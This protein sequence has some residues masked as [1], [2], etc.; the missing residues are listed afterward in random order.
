MRLTFL[1][2]LALRAVILVAVIVIFGA[3]AIAALNL[4]LTSYIDGPDFRAELDRQT[5]KGL[6]FD[7]KYGTIKRSGFLTA[8]ADTFHAENGVKAMK[9][10]DASGIDAKFNPLGVFLRRWQL[11]YVRIK[12]GDVEI[13]TYEPKPDRKPQKPWYS[14]IMPERVHLKEVI[15][16]TANIRWNIRNKPGGILDTY[17]RILPYGRDF[18]YFADGGRFETGGLTPSLEVRKIHLTITKKALTVY[19]FELFPQGSTDSLLSMTG[20]VGMREDKHVDLRLDIK[21]MPIAPWLP[22]EVEGETGGNVTGF[23]EWKADGQTIEA[24]SGSGGLSVSGGRLSGLPLLE[25]L[26]SAA[27]EKN[28][29]TLTL[30]ECN[31]EFQWKY[32]RFEISSISLEAEEKVALRGSLAVRNG[33]LDGTCE[34]GLDPEY[35]DWLPKAEEEVFTRRE[36]GMIW[37]TV[38]ISGTLAKPEN[39]LTPRLKEA[40]KKDPAAAA[41]LFLRGAGEWIEQKLKG[42]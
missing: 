19:Q 41:G 30:R 23:V 6:H 5:S 31:V 12:H 39:D 37:T 17:V 9:R 32:P 2:R 33:K 24:S 26:A 20:D 15:C 36:N 40:L 28:L 21:N 7:G 18:R 3:L 25:F 34:L 29:K 8:E 22:S 11:D 1:P 16:D 4:R 14:F 35:L 42:N 38:R 10:L 27:A 13:Q